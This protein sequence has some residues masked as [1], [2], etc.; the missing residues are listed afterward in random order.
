MTQPSLFHRFTTQVF[1]VS[2]TMTETKQKLKS[3]S[4]AESSSDFTQR[5]EIF[6]LALLIVVGL[7]FY[8]RMFNKYFASD[9]FSV[10]YRVVYEHGIFIKGFFR[11]LSDI[12]LYFN[13]MMGGFNPA[14]YNV[15]SFIIHVLTVF[16]FYKLCVSSEWVK[17]ENQFYFALAA[18]VFFMLYPYHNEPVVWVVGRASL[19]ASFFGIASLLIITQN[20][21]IHWKIFL[22]CLF[23][24]VGLSGYESIMPLPF[25]L[26]ILF[27]DRGNWKR[28]FQIFAWLMVT[29]LLHLLT[30]FLVSD[31]IVGS[32]GAGM[33]APDTG[34][35]VQ[36]FLKVLGRSFI[37]PLEDT[38]LAIGLFVVVMI[39]LVVAEI[40]LF[41]NRRRNSEPFMVFNRMLI[42]F[43][44]SLSVAFM[45][46]V[47]TRTY[48]GDRLLYFPS[49]F[50]CIS[51]AFL[52]TVLFKKQALR[53]IISLL[54]CLYFAWFLLQNNRY[55][56][57]ASEITVHIINVFKTS[58]NT[59]EK[60]VVNLPEEYHGAY[61]FRNGFREAL[62]LNQ[63]DTSGVRIVNFIKSEEMD[64]VSGQ[65]GPVIAGDSIYLPPFTNVI[66]I[67][68][69]GGYKI[70]SKELR[71]ESTDSGMVY[72]YYWNKQRLNRFKL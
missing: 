56:T 52:V 30:R 61:I 68:T 35:Y 71:Y 59:G 2:A 41:R 21:K 51:L 19:M 40:L 66:R 48:E 69:G 28:Y 6:V 3:R 50:L 58:G 72:I 34:F 44:V 55:W 60:L 57:K 64:A 11:P 24:Y 42:A 65:F 8:Y 31:V 18:A 54:I 53:N 7:G 43:I 47:S 27:A 15:F 38:S 32:Y 37:P 14:Y 26:L 45:F 5:R 12:T 4:G 1:P 36:R 16:M 67:G 23:Y 9:D 39:I 49:F 17:K 20:I 63:I 29:L 25:I 10:L 33:F 46:G 22:S 70:L 13:Y 62:L